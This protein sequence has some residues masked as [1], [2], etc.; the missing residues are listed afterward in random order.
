MAEQE[1][2][3][4][5]FGSKPPP[6]PFHVFPASS[7]SVI[8][9]PR[10]TPSVLDRYKS[11]LILFATCICG[12]F[13]QYQPVSPLIILFQTGILVFIHWTPRWLFRWLGTL[14]V[15][16]VLSLS[17]AQVFRNDSTSDWDWTSFGY[18]VGIDMAVGHLFFLLAIIHNR[19]VSWSQSRVFIFTYPTLLTTVYSVM[20]IFTPLGTLTNI[21]Y[22]FYDWQSFIQVVSLF[23]VSSLT[24]IILTLAV[25]VA[26]MLVIDRGPRRRFVKIFGASLFLIN[27]LFGSIRLLAPYMFQLT[28]EDTA[29]PASDWVNAACVTVVGDSAD[30]L[31]MTTTLLQA[32]PTIQFVM[33]T[34]AAN[35]IV[36]YDDRSIPNPQFWQEPRLTPFI[37]Q[38]TALSKLY[39]ATIASTYAVWANPSDIS[40]IS[41]YNN[42]MMIDPIAGDIGEYSKVHPVPIIEVGVIPGPDKYMMPGTSTNIGSFTVGICFDFDFPLFVRDSLAQLEHGAGGLMLQPANT[43]GFIGRWHGVSSSFRAIETG[44]YL[45]R[46]GSQG[47]SGLWDYYGNTLA[48]QSRSDLG[49]VQFQV[50]LNPPR[51][52]T[53]YSS[54]GF[55]FDFLVYAFAAIFLGMFFY[56]LCRPKKEPRDDTRT[57]AQIDVKS[58]I[59][60]NPINV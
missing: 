7:S 58:P 24:W 18:I 8:T 11:I 19:L 12:F 1:L 15:S 14:I 56:S 28:I 55:C 52:W 34:E 6:V 44:T 23:G 38:V 49:V 54:F 57:S 26:H 9:N 2:R 41:L 17:M 13:N 60:T 25:C 59:N 10:A 29:I 3:T 51:I 33:W 46:C 43:W 27:W 30:P 50:P 5:S 37:N 16:L 36:F 20:G 42:V 48:Y 22:A 4:F 35:R 32:D 45:A 47:P 39:N 31:Q 40:D 21:G 53:V